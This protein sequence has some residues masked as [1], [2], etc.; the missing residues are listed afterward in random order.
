MKKNKTQG[1]EVI[2]SAFLSLKTEAAGRLRRLPFI[3]T[4]FDKPETIG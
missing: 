1:V 2:R 4:T 3:F